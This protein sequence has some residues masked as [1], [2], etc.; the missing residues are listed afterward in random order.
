MP[1]VRAAKTEVGTR[2]V[3][4]APAVVSMLREWKL[5][6][7]AGE[8]DLVFPNGVGNPE[9]HQNILNRGFFPLQVSAGI[10]VESGKVGRAGKPIMKAKYALHA[11]RH[12]AAALFIEQAMKPKRIQAIMGHAS[13]QMTYDLYGYLLEAKDED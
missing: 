1:S 3:P 11:L 6:C 2:D 5:A 9:Y 10:T 4:L 7:P 13:I 8:H 12:A